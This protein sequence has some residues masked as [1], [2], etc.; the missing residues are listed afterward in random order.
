M[1][2]FFISKTVF[3]QYRYLF[4]SHLTKLFLSATSMLNSLPMFTG[5]AKAEHQSDLKIVI[6][7]S[8]FTCGTHSGQYVC[9]FCCCQF[10][11]RPGLS[12]LDYRCVLKQHLPHQPCLSYLHAQ[13]IFS[14]VLKVN[15]YQVLL[16]PFLIYLFLKCSVSISPI[17]ISQVPL[18]QSI[19]AN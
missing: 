6:S 2:V 3:L 4:H 17:L 14:V 13:L 12:H 16:L 9:P 1:I 5:F 19:F 11:K 18:Y 7:M 8:N 10:G 15:R